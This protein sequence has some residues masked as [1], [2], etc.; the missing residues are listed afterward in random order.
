MAFALRSG[1]Q[2]PGHRSRRRAQ[3]HPYLRSGEAPPAAGT[4]P[5]QPREVEFGSDTGPALAPP[6]FGMPSR[7]VGC[8]PTMDVIHCTPPALWALPDR[9]DVGTQISRSLV[10]FTY[11]GEEGLARCPASRLGSRMGT[12]VVVELEVAVECGVPGRCDGEEPSA[13]LE[14]SELAGDGALTPIDKAAAPVMPKLAPSMTDV[15]LVANPVE[16][17]PAFVAL[18]GQDALKQ[19]ADSLVVRQDPACQEACGDLGRGPQVHPGHGEGT[20]RV[21]RLVL[22]NP[23]DTL[24]LA[25]VDRVQAP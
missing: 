6:P 13:K 17:A 3:E 18:I 8:P 22:P 1:Q 16:G 23:P 9:V 25:H 24:R 10:T 5:D 12:V 20:G 11:P 2:S 14:A 7:L 21:A 19:A 4:W 15:P